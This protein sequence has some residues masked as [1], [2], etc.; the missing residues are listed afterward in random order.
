MH[1][2]VNGYRLLIVDEVGYHLPMSREQAKLFIQA[3]ARRYERSSMIL[4]SNVTFGSW[5]RS[6][7]LR[8]RAD[9]GDARP[10]P[11]AFDPSSTSTA[12]A[13]GSRTNAKLASCRSKLKHLRNDY[14]A[15]AAGEKT[16]SGSILL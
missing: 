12:R 7:W 4:T 8:Q 1:H 5:G 11:S 2:A 14:S 6:V 13:I 9:R 3:V 15:A 10:H 16:D